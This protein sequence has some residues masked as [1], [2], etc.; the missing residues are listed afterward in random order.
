M[1]VEETDKNSVRELDL[2]GHYNR[3]VERASYSDDTGVCCDRFA[4]EM[5]RI[6]H[7]AAR[8]TVALGVKSVHS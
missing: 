5:G 6:D 7:H 1:V 8:V 2:D 4:V 3:T